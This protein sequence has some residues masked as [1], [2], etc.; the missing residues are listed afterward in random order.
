MDDGGFDRKMFIDVV[1]G[2]RKFFDVNKCEYL[3]IYR[4]KGSVVCC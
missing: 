2:K 4:V 3:W 1:K